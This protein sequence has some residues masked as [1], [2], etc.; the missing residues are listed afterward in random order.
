MTALLLLL[1]TFVLFLDVTTRRI[2]V[3]NTLT[4]DRAAV[5]LAEH[6]LLSMREKGLD[7]NGMAEGIRV[8]RLSDPAPAGH[9]WVQVHAQVGGRSASLVGLVPDKGGL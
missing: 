5:R 2:R 1:I 3:A 9:A 6:V 8:E 4:N 7:Q